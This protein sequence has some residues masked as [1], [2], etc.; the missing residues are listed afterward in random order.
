M[1]GHS[2]TRDSAE[3]VSVVDLII[4][5]YELICPKVTCRQKKVF[6]SQLGMHLILKPFL[7]HF[8]YL[9]LYVI[10]FL[11]LFVYLFIGLLFWTLID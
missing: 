2:R 5:Y 3:Q 1:T 7:K 6:L 8:A 9:Y 11:S 10:Y 4:S